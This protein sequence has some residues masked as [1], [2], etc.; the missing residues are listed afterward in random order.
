MGIKKRMRVAKYEL[1]K[2]TKTFPVLNPYTGEK[3]GE[4]PQANNAI[5]QEVIRNAFEYKSNFSASVRS[6]ML[7]SIADTI[8]AQGKA[9][10]ELITSESGLS[11]EG[12][13]R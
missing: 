8:E 6:K 7:N 2:T 5:I 10:A 9:C 4:A 3:V 11:I 12:F 1:F 13:H